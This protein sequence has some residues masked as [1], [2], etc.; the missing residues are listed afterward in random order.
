M[1]DLIELKESEYI[2]VNH[3]Q[4]YIFIA[5][6]PA[7]HLLFTKFMS[8]KKSESTKL[9]V[10]DLFDYLENDKIEISYF[11]YAVMD[12]GNEFKNEF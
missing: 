8:D 6:Q 9:A 5:Y 2:E 3:S 11:S 4:G 1:V 12:E 10:Q 7:N